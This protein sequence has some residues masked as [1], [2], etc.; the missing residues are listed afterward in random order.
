VTANAGVVVDNITIDGNDIS[1]TNSNGNLT[2]TP[3]GTGNVN[4]NSDTVAIAGTEGESA[5]L[6]LAADES[7]D[8]ADI[9]KITSNTDNTLTIANQISG[10]AV[11][12][13]TFTPNATVANSTAAFAGVITVPSD[14]THAGDTDTKLQFNAADSFRII[15][16][17]E[18]R[19]KANN[20]EVVVNDNSADMDF[21]VESNGNANMLLVDA[22]ND[23]VGIGNTTQWGGVLNVTSSDN[24]NTLVL[25]C[26]DTDA[27]PGPILSL[28][29]S[30]SSSAAD[31]DEIGIINVQGLNDANQAITYASLGSLIED[32]TDG[33]EDG[34]FIL[35]TMVAGTARSRMAV[36][37]ASGTVFNEDSIDL[38]FRVETDA[39]THGFFL[40]ASTNNAGFSVTP[41]TDNLSSFNSVQF[42]QSGII[43]TA[44][45]SS[46]ISV[47]DNV[48]RASSGSTGYKAINTGSS[49]MMTMSGGDIA[50]YSNGNASAGADV[51]LHNSFLI[52]NNITYNGKAGTSPIF[53]LINND[54]EDTNT[55]RET[56]VRFSG[57]RSGG[58]DVVNA[59]ISGSH[60][61]SADDDKG[62]LFFY[63]N[64]GA[65]I[66]E[67]MRI[68]E[69]AVIFNADGNEQ[70]FRV[71]TDDATHAL[72]IDGA[73][74]FLA[75]GKNTDGITTRGSAFSNLQAGGH[76][77]FGICNTDSSSS[78]SAMY[79]NRQDADGDLITF[80]QANTTEGTI[81]V[82]GSTVSY[83]G[84]AGRHESS[85]IATNTAVGTVVSTIDELDVYPDTQPDINGGEIPSPKAGQ[86][87]AD[88][89]KVKVSDAVSDTRVYGVVAEFTAQGKA[90]VTSVGIGSVKVTGACAGGDLLESNGDGT[91][92]VQSDDIIRSST[93]GK[94]T[95]GNSET[96]VKIVSCVLYCG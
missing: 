4:I 80:R 59:Q 8:N 52:S 32:A 68:D 94:V 29:R 49:A 82:S 34:M 12:H 60:S 28:Y 45:A 35:K 33:H 64:S 6:L 71:A 51:T 69:N 86:T 58:E 76:H 25:A 9:W 47:N 75:I 18:E 24:G 44:P 90:I 84:F 46:F 14:I 65:G 1:T 16:G 95:I 27:S 91:A 70:Y 81:A 11:A 13:A 67:R 22:G 26:T 41:I 96:G 63:T 55:G 15:T 85:G 56:S 2:I 93:I 83:N 40:D 36:T 7:D 57:H 31:S 72:Y 77:Y 88:H 10:S 30:S 19:L 48:Y 39:Q 17:D 21:R 79:I 78:N 89:A 87:R 5:S 73:S 37:T 43:Q 38:D 20:G 74:D 23:F 54:N 62:M 3:N 66:G 53:E 42:G 61:G 92:K 50:F